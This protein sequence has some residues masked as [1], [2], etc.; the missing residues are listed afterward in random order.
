MPSA[1]VTEIG[2]LSCTYG[3]IPMYSMDEVVLE[4]KQRW[5]L[6]PIA[7]KDD[8]LAHWKGSDPIYYDI[9]FDLQVGW[10]EIKDYDTLIKKVKIYHAMAAQEGNDKEAAPPPIVTF[11]LY[12]IISSPGVLTSIR[13]AFKRPFAAWMGVAN[14]HSVKFTGQFAFLPG[15]SGGS[16]QGKLVDVVKQNQLMNARQIANNL[17]LF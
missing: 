5:D 14:P 7:Y 2:R 6:N 17:Y 16:A 10:G 1:P 9:D 11:K 15:V 4:R 8:V 13:T 12:G 3:T